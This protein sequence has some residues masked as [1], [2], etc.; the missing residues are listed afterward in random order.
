M[1][2]SESPRPCP[3][4]PRRLRSSVY[5][6]HY[7]PEVKRATPT[8]I[9]PNRINIVEIWVQLDDYWEESHARQNVTVILR[10]NWTLHP[11]VEMPHPLATPNKIPNLHNQLT[12][13]PLPRPSLHPRPLYYPDPDRSFHPLATTSLNGDPIIA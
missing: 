2:S 8:N 3:P 6:P 13:P 7:C 4:A 5:T 9:I 10:H 11:I 12:P 1:R